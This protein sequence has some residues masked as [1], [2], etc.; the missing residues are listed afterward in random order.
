MLLIWPHDRRVHLFLTPDEESFVRID[1]FTTS[2]LLP[3]PVS[4]VYLYNLNLGQGAKIFIVVGVLPPLFVL[5]FLLARHFT[6]VEEERGRLALQEEVKQRLGAPANMAEI[7]ERMLTIM[8]QL[9]DYRWGAVYSLVDGELE[10]CGEKPHKGRV[11]ILD[12][13][14]AGETRTPSEEASTE[15]NQVVWPLQVKPGEGIL[16]KLAKAHFPLPPRFFDHGLEPVTLSDPYL[17][18]KTAL[19]VYP[20]T[21]EAQ[22]EVERLRPQPIGMIALARPR[23]LF[24]IRDWERGL[25][26]SGEARNALL[27]VQRLER[28]FQEIY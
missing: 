13:R 24:T 25:A 19:A 9:M 16:G 23:R 27:S 12:Q 14:K 7:V 3:L 18:P 26:L 10:L 8:G 22:G 11:V 2:L 28:T 15:E 4:V 1:I 17:P 20:I 6:E 5:L 21:V